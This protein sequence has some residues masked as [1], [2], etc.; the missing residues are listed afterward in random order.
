VSQ[1]VLEASA[2]AVHKIRIVLRFLLGAL[3]GFTS[4]IDKD[5]GKN[6]YFLDRYLLHLLFDFDHHVRIL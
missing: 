1:P 2:E 3:H 5:V 4:D 6:L